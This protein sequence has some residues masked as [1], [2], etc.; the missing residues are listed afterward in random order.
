MIEE[1][2]SKRL[3]VIENQALLERLHRER[4][5][6]DRACKNLQK[7]QRLT[8]ESNDS[9][10]A[11]ATPGEGR[12]IVSTGNISLYG[13]QGPGTMNPVGASGW[14]NMSPSMDNPRTSQQSMPIDLDLAY[15]E[16]SVPQSEQ[17]NALRQKRKAERRAARHPAKQAKTI[18]DD[19]E[20]SGP[21][22]AQGL[23]FGEYQDAVENAPL[24]QDFLSR[25]Q[26]SH[27]AGQPDTELRATS[28]I[29]NTNAINDIAR[30]DQGV[31]KGQ[32]GDNL[33]PNL[34][35][36]FD[37]VSTTNVNSEGAH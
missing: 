18:L 30:P 5:D 9:S 16:G 23:N 6:A 35:S 26:L 37:G 21:S 32:V 34:N 28:T 20:E 7:Q 24:T 3:L 25:S 31:A 27:P 1:L 11:Y 15:R 29:V 13:R 33:P 2:N 19:Q 36:S 8:E 4:A 12:R 22:N 14:G 17:D 10:Y